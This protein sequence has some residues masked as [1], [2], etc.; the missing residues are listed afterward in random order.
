M[1]TGAGKKF[2]DELFELNE[3]FITHPSNRKLAKQVIYT[4]GKTPEQFCTE[5]LRGQCSLLNKDR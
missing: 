2:S 3:Y 1:L 4:K 5:I